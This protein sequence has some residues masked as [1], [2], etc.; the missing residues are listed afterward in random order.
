MKGHQKI[1]GILLLKILHGAAKRIHLR[2]G[3][4]P[5]QGRFIGAAGL[6]GGERLDADE[7]G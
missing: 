3:V 7:I 4:L 5:P 1:A 2:F 6:K